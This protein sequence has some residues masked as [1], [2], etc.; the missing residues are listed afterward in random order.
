MGSVDSWA[1]ISLHQYADFTKLK[2]KNPHLKTLIAMGGW[3][4]SQGTSKYSNLVSDADRIAN[5]ASQAVA[6][7]QQYNFDGL[8]I[9]WEYPNSGADRSGFVALITALR[10]AFAPHGLM[11]TVATSA[12]TAQ[13]DI[14][15]DM[16]AISQL[17]DAVHMMAYDFHG[18]WENVTD[19]HAPLYRRPYDVDSVDNIDAT[20]DYWL[21]HGASADKLILGIPMYGRSFHLASIADSAPLSPVTGPGAM[22]QYTK[23]AGFL[24]FYEICQQVLNGWVNVV[25]ETG[26]MGPYAYSGNTGD[27]VGYDDVAMVTR[28]AAYVQEKG[29]G[30]AMFWD[31][32]C[33][34]FHN[35]CGLGVNPLLTAV[36]NQLLTSS[37]SVAPTAT[38]T[39]SSEL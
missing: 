6:F 9:D 21:D 36:S 32:S 24:A 8:D 27:W 33:D 7:L 35:V 2:L 10:Q 12:S 3:N 17:V 4:D 20:I 5:F 11:L 39:V 1:D 26:A 23:E 31:L 18:S 25:D 29:L 28:K 19:H 16:A 37:T 13:A 38:S 14:G 22:G 15:Y 34:D 30:G